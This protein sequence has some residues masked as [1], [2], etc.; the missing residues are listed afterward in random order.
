MHVTDVGLAGADDPKVLR[1]AQREHRIVVT[2]NYQDFA[3]LTQALASRGESFPGVLFY[4][5]SIRPSDVDGHVKA[6][7]AWVRQ[8]S[9]SEVNPVANGFGW[10][11][12]ANT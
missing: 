10:L 3:P 9:I 12:N 4:P 11:S 5:S 1:W 7:L 2:R 6:L 8:A